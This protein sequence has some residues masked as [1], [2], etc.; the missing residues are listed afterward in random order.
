VSIEQWSC[1]WFGMMLGVILTSEKLK[2]WLF[3]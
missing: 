1:F 3:Q 2:S